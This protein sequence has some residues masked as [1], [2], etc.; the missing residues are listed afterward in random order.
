MTILSGM[1]RRRHPRVD[2]NLPAIYRSAH[3]TMDTYV[4]NL[5]QGGLALAAPHVDLTGTECE[6]LVT[7]PGRADQLALH[8]KI[9]WIDTSTETPTMGFRFDQLSRD[10]RVALANFLLARFYN[11]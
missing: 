4:R 2:L 8:G 5:S 6:L 1:E 3:R 11:T 7:L 10:Q 9:I